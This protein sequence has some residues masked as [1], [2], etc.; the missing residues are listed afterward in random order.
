MKE[1]HSVN[2]S[3][4]CH[5][6]PATFDN[7]AAYKYHVDNHLRVFGW[8]Q[9]RPCPSLSCNYK[10]SSPEGLKRHHREDHVS[11]CSHQPQC[12]SCKFRN[13]SMVGVSVHNLHEHSPEVLAKRKAAENA[14]RA[15]QRAHDR[16]V[17]VR[18]AQAQR[19]A[20]QATAS[21]TPSLAPSH[22]ASGSS[23]NAPPSPAEPATPPPPPPPSD[24]RG[25]N[26]FLAQQQQFLESLSPEERRLIMGTHKERR[27][28]ERR[29]RRRERA[30][31][32]TGS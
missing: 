28:A 23:S 15:K 18:L 26:D 1:V 3:W 2:K 17:A 24:M 4:L 20:E 16:D 9:A 14:R 7:G 27:A 32:A 12:P 21:P 30:G 13:E 5:E 31:M 29:R 10:D 25:S 6:C 19:T 8:R 22:D 11:N